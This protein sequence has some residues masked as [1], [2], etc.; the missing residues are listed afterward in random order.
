VKLRILQDR[1]GFLLRLLLS[2]PWSIQSSSSMKRLLFLI[3]SL[4]SG[5]VAAPAFTSPLNAFLPRFDAAACCAC[6]LEL[7]G[8]EVRPVNPLS[9]VFSTF[10]LHHTN[11]KSK[12]AGGPRVC[13]ADCTCDWCGTNPLNATYGHPCAE[14]GSPGNWGFC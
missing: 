4:I 14:A 6:F 9:S 11:P 5:S 7:W 1:C 2:I 12:I 8:T 13:D 10:E 3:T